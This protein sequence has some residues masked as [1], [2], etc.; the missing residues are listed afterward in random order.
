MKKVMTDGVHLNVHESSKFK[1]TAMTVDFVGPLDHRKF[2]A[3]AMVAEMM[4]NYSQKYNSKLKVARR[5]SELFGADFGTNVFKIGNRSVL[6]VVMSF[7]NNDF[8]LDNSDVLDEAL[9]FLAEM[10]F[11]PNQADHQYVDDQFQIQRDN[12]VQY[13]NSLSDDRRYYA[14]KRTRELYFYGQPNYSESVIGSPQQ[15]MSLK[16]QDV[17]NEL[18][19]TLAN[20]EIHISILGQLSPKQIEDVQ[21]HLAFSPRP[22]LSSKIKPELG[23]SSEQSKVETIKGEQSKLDLA[24][25]FP[26]LIGDR[27]YFSAIVMNALLGGMQ[28]SLMFHNIREKHSLAYYI[29]SSYN[30]TLG[31]VAI[32]SGINADD[33]EEV[34]A[35]IHQQIDL[36][37]AQ[38]YD[39]QR[40]LD[41]KS[42]LI[43]GYDSK[44]DS[45]RRTLNGDF[46]NELYGMDLSV[47]QWIQ[48]IRAVTKDDL[49]KV[50]SMMKL[51]TRFLLKGTNNG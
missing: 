18:K 21:H 44:F 10:I 5:L 49:S 1:T 14:L 23:Q 42:A 27:N 45:Q 2:A 33:A 24:F 40:F 6:R 3:R 12:L 34:E 31:Y 25:D 36:I 37:K 38:K 8:T 13:L 15:V 28:Q 41:V 4:E 20:D 26:I 19:N 29:S 30:S 50:A 35:L 32:E 17:L 46:V 47:D 9:A 48:K 39:D 51:K 11:H 22:D 43:D 7:V 16:N